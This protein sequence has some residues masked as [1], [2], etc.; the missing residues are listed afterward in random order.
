MS[1]YGGSKNV[2]EDFNKLVTAG[3]ASGLESSQIPEFL[4]GIQKVMEDGIAKGFERSAT[5]VADTLLMFSKMSG[6]NAFWQGE[7]GAKLLNQ[8]NSGIASSTA[9]S[10]TEDIIVYSAIANAYKGTTKDKNG[11]IISKAEAALGDTYLKDGGY[12][13][14]MQLIEQG[15]NSDNFGS[16]MDAL[17]SS[18]GNNTEA[19]IEA[20]RKMTGLNY[21]GAARLLNLDRNAGS[22]A[23]NGVLT[24]PEN[25]NKETRYQEAVNKISESVIKIGEG[26]AELKIKDMSR[27]ANLVSGIA[28]EVAGSNILDTSVEVG[29]DAENVDIV[30]DVLSADAKKK[31]V[32]GFQVAEVGDDLLGGWSASEGPVWELENKILNPQDVENLLRTGEIGEKVKTLAGE[33]TED[34]EDFYSYIWNNRKSGNPSDL[35]DKVIYWSNDTHLYQGERNEIKKLLEQIW[36]EFK[37]G[38]NLTY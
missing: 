6:G 2:S 28:L 37:E 22:T 27:I 5:E 7:Q 29:T 8:V 30:K 35:M 38:I 36:S 9:L 32:F 13:N 12:V 16:I 21:T 20:L 34:I 1:R 25:Q 33:N 3:Y 23:I 24:S 4:S 14:T 31:S 18:Y 19:K 10:K 15:I 26:T 11:N 17:D